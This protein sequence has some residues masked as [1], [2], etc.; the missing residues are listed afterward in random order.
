MSY[1][2]YLEEDAIRIALANGYIKRFIW[3]KLKRDV[4]YIP[5]MPSLAAFRHG[6]GDSDNQL[7]LG[8][9]L[10]KRTGRS[11]PTDGYEYEFEKVIGEIPE[12]MKREILE[13][14]E[15]YLEKK[16][17]R[18]SL[19]QSIASLEDMLKNIEEDIK[20]MEEAL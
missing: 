5:M 1:G 2:I 15:I 19:R 20:K 16:D 7:K 18:E 13:R 12:D 8:E 6:L 4:L 3:S 11:N 9:F 17:Y 14:Q 10:Y